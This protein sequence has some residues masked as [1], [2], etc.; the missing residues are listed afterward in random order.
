MTSQPY[1]ESSE[2]LDGLGVTYE[3]LLFHGQQHLTGK[4]VRFPDI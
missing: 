2:T 3:E 4:R 1:S